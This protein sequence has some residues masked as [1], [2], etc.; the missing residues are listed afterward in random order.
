MYKT[1]KG[2]EM[3]NPKR[4]VSIIVPIMNEV[5]NI[6]IFYDAVIDVIHNLKELN[7]EFIFV[8]DG[9]T[10][11]SVEHLL[12]LREKDSRIRIIQLSRNFGSY[13][14]LRAGLAEAK[15]DAAITISA[16]LQ[17]NPQIFDSF[18]Q[19]WENGYDIVWGVRKKRD[20]PW[21]KK[22]LAFSFYQLIRRIALPSLPVAGMDCGLFDRKIIEA[23]LKISDRNNVTFMTIY[24]MGFRQAF[25]YY[26]RKKR[27]FG[28]SKWPLGKR[29]K[30]ALDVITS[31]SYLPIRFGSFL[32]LVV[33]AISII[34]ASGML[35]SKLTIS[36][37]TASWL[38]VIIIG[39]FL[40][41]LQ[42]LILGIMGEYL[43]RISSEV[44]GRPEYI[45]MK[46]IGF[47]TRNDD[48][49]K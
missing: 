42:L 22:L 35:F 29:I 12:L 20:D 49:G 27:R 38:L 26:D 14:A 5:E 37:E 41:G 36:K 18:V 4:L 47:A 39:L 44:R 24:W 28:K 23:F 7:W 2:E 46:K 13:A 45:I 30:A 15:G 31:F 48:A 1:R 40:G 16:D 33:S 8:D 11:Q 19:H 43:W 32:G 3:L 6:E 21:A 9:S 10:D 34:L 17:D 25:I